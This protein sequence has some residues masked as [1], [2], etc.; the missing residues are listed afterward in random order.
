MKK[1]K[2]ILLLMLF[3][4]M[5]AS[6][7]ACGNQT[8]RQAIEKEQT[9]TKETESTQKKQDKE[10]K[11]E[12]ST[13]KTK[14]TERVDA[15]GET[16]ADDTKKTQDTGYFSLKAMSD[17][18]S[19]K[20]ADTDIFDADYQYYLVKD[21]GD[22]SDAVVAAV[23]DALKADLDN[24][25]AAAEEVLDSAKDAYSNYAAYEGSASEDTESGFIPYAYRYQ[26]KVVRNDE[27]VLSFCFRTD[28]N[29]QGAH[30]DYV[31][32]CLNFDAQTGEQIIWDTLS[33]DPESLKAQ[34]LSQVE[35]LAKTDDYK[36]L[37]YDA[38][39]NIDFSSVI[40]ADGTFALTETG[41]EIVANPY[42][43]GPY[44]SGAITFPLTWEQLDGIKDAFV[45]K[46]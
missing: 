27:E 16:E 28:S 30:G 29:Q 20:E 21:S 25:K 19:K 37:F 7:T 22:A 12:K 23:N 38:P 3:A 34:V 42:D 2:Q 17:S 15:I 8:V 39:E 14:G 31:Y 10:A 33:D 26:A 1:T 24:Q 35:T 43:L 36:E 32:H 11:N 9:G 41:M 40:F 13:E 46:S 5:A 18:D 45:Y 6:V 44:A 4:G